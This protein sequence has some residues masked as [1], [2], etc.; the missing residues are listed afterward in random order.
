MRPMSSARFLLVLGTLL[1][2]AQTAPHRARVVWS[3]ETTDASGYVSMDG[4]WL[5]YMNYG[6][7][8]MWARDLA[9]GEKRRLTQKDTSNPSHFPYAGV[10][11]PDGTQVVYSVAATD[12]VE[13][14]L[15]DWN[16]GNV[17]VLQS[18]P[19]MRFTP[20]AWTHDSKRI[21]CTR[22]GLIN[23]SSEIGFWDIEGNRFDAV[24]NLTPM[25]YAS[26]SPDDSQIVAS[27]L[28]PKDATRR[29]LVLIDARSGVITPPFPDHEAEDWAPV[30]AQKGRTLVFVSNR[31]G[32]PKLWRVA[33][34]GR[35]VKGVPVPIADLP[36]G[37]DTI[38]GVT[39]DDV[40]F[41]GAE[42]ID[43]DRVFVGTVDWEGGKIIGMSQ[44][45]TPPFTGA[46]R[47]SF[48]PDGKK[49]AFLRKGRGANV[50]PGWQTPVVRDLATDSDRVYKTPLTLRDEPVWWRSGRSLLFA[51]NPEGN[52]GEGG[53]G[54]WTFREIDLSTGSWRMVGSAAAPGQVRI[55]GATDTY[56]TYLLNDFANSTGTLM[57]LDV[58]SGASRVLRQFK[59][60]LS[61]AAVSPDAKNIA[62]AFLRA[63]G[64]AE[65][66]SA[67]QLLDL[68]QGTIRDLG[69]IR[70]NAR[71]QLVWFPDS[72]SFVMS[73][74]IENQDGLWRLF[75]SDEQP[76]RTQLDIPNVSEARI[77]N[78]TKKVA[79]TQ[80]ARK[81][82]QVVAVNLSGN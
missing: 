64:G 76:R 24:A 60:T 14:R 63:Q 18:A 3:D 66:G 21:L 41:A 11:S 48:S 81:P 72:A 17:R 23:D 33:I 38:L 47:P 35:T 82:V 74:R 50:R 71:P 37:F 26:L 68:G 6:A 22:H 77:S 1:A 30:W 2:F 59:T 73:G 44:V 78:D 57:A 39:P 54:V 31:G 49:L 5:T 43:G 65:G 46:R 12:R 4:R 52:L 55:A 27:S 7:G 16:G 56:I 20:R 45:Q 40:V 79:F 53:A 29:R 69:S 15:S 61:E 9:T 10:I 80:R 25:V 75:L 42:D 58:S 19:A 62:V 13:L 8:E 36:D 67:V 51:T 70:P 34:E 28:D 32:G